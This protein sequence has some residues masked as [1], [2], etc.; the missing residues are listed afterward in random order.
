MKK[1]LMIVGIIVILLTVELSGCNENTS[2]L[3][4]EKII[5]TWTKRDMYNGSIR[6][7]SYIFYI[8]KTFKVVSSYKDEFLNVNGTWNITDNKLIMISEDKTVTAD[9]KFSEL[10]K[11][12]ILTLTDKSG[13]SVDFVK[14]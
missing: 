1:Q 8:N 6:S 14:E 13:N 9:Y 11:N 7:N 3:D 5:G 4:E 10:N 2:K 12:K